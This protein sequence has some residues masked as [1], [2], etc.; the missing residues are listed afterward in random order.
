VLGRYEEALAEY[1]V[2]WGPES[3]RFRTFREAFDR[4]GPTGA[5]NELAVRL[6]ERA[7]TEPIDPRDIAECY[8]WAGE[9]DSAFQWLERAYDA[10][11]PMLLHTPASPHFDSLHSDPRFDALM[12][13]I[14]IPRGAK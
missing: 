11:S 1:E 7:E 14:G 9:N 5:L 2:Y 8:A 10:R 3:D 4:L 6:A 13:R 12:Q